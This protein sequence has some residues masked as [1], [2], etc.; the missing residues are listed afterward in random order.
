MKKIIVIIFLGLIVSV[1]AVW[2]NGGFNHV[3][4]PVEQNH[5]HFPNPTPPPVSQL[6]VE[7]NLAVPFTTQAPKSVWDADHEE[8]C[9][10]AAV[11]MAEVYVNNQSIPNADFAD[12]QLYSMKDY[13]LQTFGYFKDTTA[14][15]TAK[16]LTDFYHVKNVQLVNNPTLDQIKQTLASGKVIIEPAAGR[17]LGNPNFTGA[18]PLYH[19]ILLKGYTKDGK[20]ITNDPGT[21]K[22]ANYI[23]SSQTILDAMHDWNGGDVDHGAKVI[24][25]VG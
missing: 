8:F 22:G 1:S 4:V 13:E 21:R 16:I 11:L 20:I 24:I 9:E 23:Y 25:V 18:G 6:P 7:I 19:N 2:Y 15:E 3:Q 14:A 17:M 5:N 12:S 10:E